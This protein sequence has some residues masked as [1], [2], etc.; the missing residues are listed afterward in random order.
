MMLN[1]IHSRLCDN[2]FTAFSASYGLIVLGK[3]EAFNRAL[4]EI[5]YQLLNLLV[6]AISLDIP[7][8]AVLLDNKQKKLVTHSGIEDPVAV[9]TI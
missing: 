3:N 5:G 6:Q 1:K 9:S 8:K 7:Y 2:L 4:W